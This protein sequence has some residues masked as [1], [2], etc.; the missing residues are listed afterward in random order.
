MPLGLGR[1]RNQQNPPFGGFGQRRTGDDLA[2]A[3]P[4]SPTDMV[5]PGTPSGLKDTLK[6]G[7]RQILPHIG[8]AGASILPAG[9]DTLAN[10]IGLQ[11]QIDP[12]LMNRQLAQI[13]QSTQ[14]LQTAQ[15]GELARLGITGSGVGQGIHAAL[16]MSGVGKQAQLR[17]EEQRLAEERMRKDLQ[18]LYQMILGPGLQMSGQ[19][20]GVPVTPDQPSDLEKLL[21]TGAGI[22]GNLALGGVFG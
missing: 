22:V 7:A 1:H 8:A 16:G 12:A 3:A 17:A 14:G 10:I 2:P 21:G 19:R 6:L 15:M 5:L 9:F 4:P 13:G 11:G 18:L 20:L